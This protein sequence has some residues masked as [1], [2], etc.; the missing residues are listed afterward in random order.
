MLIFGEQQHRKRKE[1]HFSGHIQMAPAAVNLQ[2]CSV[3]AK[4]RL[5]IEL[6]HS[7][8]LRDLN[9]W[10][11]RERERERD[12]KAGRYTPRVGFTDLQINIF[13]KILFNL[14]GS[15]FPPSPSSFLACF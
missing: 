15:D 1:Q 6:K 7:D 13:L 2:N 8:R 4:C 12:G 5:P 10:Y 3:S 14:L 11:P 9:R